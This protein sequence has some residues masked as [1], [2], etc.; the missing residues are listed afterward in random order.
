MQASLHLPK[1]VF[2]AHTGELTSPKICFYCPYRRAY[3]PQNLFLLPMQ[4]RLNAQ[5][6]VFV[7]H[8]GE[9][10]SPKIRFYCPYIRAYILQKFVFILIQ[11]G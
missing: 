10:T 6:S 11:S 9:L 5:I 2:I 4:A 7:A 3:I 8:A 1:S